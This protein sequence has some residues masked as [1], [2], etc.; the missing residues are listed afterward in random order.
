MV[1]AC[2]GGHRLSCDTLDDSIFLFNLHCPTIF[3]G[4]CLCDQGS[5]NID[6][7]RRFE[8]AITPLDEAEED[9]LDDYHDDL[10]CLSIRNEFDVNEIPSSTDLTVFGEHS[11]VAENILNY[12]FSN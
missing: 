9:V 2:F 3:D 5:L 8:C 6:E 7:Q 1:V 10:E 11:F 12:F 4:A